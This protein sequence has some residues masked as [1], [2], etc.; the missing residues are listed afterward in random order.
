MGKCAC[1][2]L[3]LYLKPCIDLKLVCFIIELNIDRNKIDTPNANKRYGVVS[4]K[5]TYLSN[6]DE[7]VVD[8]GLE[9]GNG[10]SVLV[11]SVPHLNSNVKTF[12]FS[13]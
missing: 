5:N 12:L 9:G 1:T 11:L 3:I 10:T 4:L 8:Q 2:I 6:T 13:C 7:H